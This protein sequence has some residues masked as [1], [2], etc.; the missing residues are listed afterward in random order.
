MTLP[1]FF[2]HSFES[3]FAPFRDTGG[4]SEEI[5]N[6]VAVRTALPYF[7][8]LVKSGGVNGFFAVRDKAIHVKHLMKPICVGTDQEGNHLTSLDR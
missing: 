6:D 2:P 5:C 4:T 8:P 3:W 1:L 7:T